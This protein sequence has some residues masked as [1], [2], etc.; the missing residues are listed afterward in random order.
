MYLVGLI[1]RIYRDARS[2]ERQTDFF[3]PSKPA[4]DHQLIQWDLGVSF[5]EV[6][7]PEREVDRA[8]VSSYKVNNMWNYTSIQPCVFMT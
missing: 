7:R 5:S 2:P 3:L 4:P 6:K 1:I 8:K